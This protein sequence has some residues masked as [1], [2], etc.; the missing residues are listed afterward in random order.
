MSL[1]VGTAFAQARFRAQPLP[2][3]TG[4]PLIEAAIT[5]PTPKTPE[6]FYALWQMGYMWNVHPRV[7][8]GATGFFGAGEEARAGIMPRLRIWVTRWAAIDAAPGVILSD[9][10]SGHTTPGFAGELALSIKGLIAP[11][12]HVEVF[13]GEEPV[14]YPGI[15]FES[16]AGAAAGVVGAVIGAIVVFR[17]AI[18]G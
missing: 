2:D 17:H 14:Y 11:M 12:V 18:A 4:F 3:C 15:R 1:F 9:A 5:K 7:G 8:L 16:H 13:D 10:R 6:E